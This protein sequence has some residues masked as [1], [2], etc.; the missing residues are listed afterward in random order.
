[1][2]KPASLAELKAELQTLPQEELLAICLRLARFKRDNKELMGFLL[3]EAHNMDHYTQQIKEMM[4]LEFA[5]VNTSNVWFAKKTIR[6]ILR[7]VSKYAKYAGSKELEAVLLIHFLEEMKQLPAHIT[8][9]PIL[10][11]LMAMQEKKTRKLIES[12][13][14]DLQYDYK[15]RLQE[16]IIA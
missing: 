12:L 8:K 16:L 4:T 3:F 2:L 14:E 9:A 5:N 13:H 6:K 11:K 7:L 1:M 15:R 10:E